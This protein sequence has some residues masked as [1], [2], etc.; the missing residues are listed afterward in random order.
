MAAS[1][2][3]SIT[4]FTVKTDLVDTIYATHINKLQEEVLAIET[5]LTASILSST[6]DST[7]H[8]VSSTPWTN[9]NLRINN[10]ERGLVNGVTVAPYVRKD[11]SN[12]VA[13]AS[14]VPLTVKQV[15]GNSSD[16]LQATDSSNNVGFKLNSIGLPYVGTYDVLY[17]GPGSTSYQ[18]INTNI[19]ANTDAIN[20]SI[21][22]LLFAGM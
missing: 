9:L 21:V 22:P 2:P 11:L 19:Q 5:T 18:T 6:Y 10:I 16:L 12:T 3:G 8:V 7:A 20:N 1:F 15:S 17:S 14:G 13:V 4:S